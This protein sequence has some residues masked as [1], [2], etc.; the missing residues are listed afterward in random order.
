MKVSDALNTRNS[1][2]AF[3][4]KPIPREVVKD[5]LLSASRSPSG[6]NLQPWHVWALGGQELARFKQLMVEPDG[7]AVG[8]QYLS[9]GDERALQKS[10]IQEW[11]RP[12]SHDW[13]SARG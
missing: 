13:N 12:L 5:I 1:V 4:D 7:R 3:L 8:I 10:A 9:A 2:R 11:R 6:G